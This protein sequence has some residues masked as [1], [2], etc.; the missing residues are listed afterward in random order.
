[1]IIWMNVG[2]H[3]FSEIVY[4][5][6]STREFYKNMSKDFLSVT[7]VYFLSDVFC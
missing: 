1:M 3:L 4:L 7:E 6:K 2:R 5:A